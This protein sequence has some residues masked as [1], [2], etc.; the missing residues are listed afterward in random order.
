LTSG[1]LK[2]NHF[3]EG[4]IRWSSDGRYVGALAQ[5]DYLVLFDTATQKW[6]TLLA[7]SVGYP[8]WSRDSQYIY[9]DTLWR[10]SPALIRVAVESGQTE[11]FP[12]NFGAYGAW[13]GLAPDDSFLRLRDRAVTFTP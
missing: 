3:P 7:L 12:V 9:C 1:Q 5:R 2:I 8:T 13:S 10:R 4:G 6:K 11:T